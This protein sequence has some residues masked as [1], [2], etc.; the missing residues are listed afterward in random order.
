MVPGIRTSQR[1]GPYSNL[2]WSPTIFVLVYGLTQHVS[3][4]IYIS[5]H[6]IF[7]AWIVVVVG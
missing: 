3:V 6:L 4:N 2:S 5:L 7:N 1:G